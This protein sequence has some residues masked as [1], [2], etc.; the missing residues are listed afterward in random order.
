MTEQI[1]TLKKQC[2]E[3]SAKN[4]FLES[5][6]KEILSHI[7]DRKH[8]GIVTNDDDN[9]SLIE[10]QLALKRQVGIYCGIV[11]LPKHRLICIFFV[12]LSFAI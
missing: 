8:Q 1:V 11:P 7:K 5:E 12:F 9:G 3:L 6:L 2:S 10:K 4:N